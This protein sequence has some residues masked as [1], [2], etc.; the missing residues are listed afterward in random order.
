MYGKY[1]NTAKNSFTINIISI[2]AVIVNM[3]LLIYF[4]PRLYIIGLSITSVPLFYI[5][6]ITYKTQFDFPLFFMKDRFSYWA[7]LMGILMFLSTYI[8]TYILVLNYNLHISEILSLCILICCL[9]SVF[10]VSFIATLID[11]I[12][13]INYFNNN[14][15]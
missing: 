14:G 8:P 12:K 10:L 15:N 5:A 9:L 3:I 11:D 2:S 1:I 7:I 6:L 4:D 13:H